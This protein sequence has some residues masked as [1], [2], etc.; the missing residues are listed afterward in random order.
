MGNKKMPKIVYDKC[1]DVSGGNGE[2]QISNVMINT[3]PITFGTT[4]NAGNAENVDNGEISNNI[5]SEKIIYFFDITVL[6]V[7]FYRT[8]RFWKIHQ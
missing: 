6:Q 3:Q 5:V 2:N 7:H 4:K 1:D 8:F